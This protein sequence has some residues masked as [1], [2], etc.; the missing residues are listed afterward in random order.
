MI[1]SKDPVDWTVDEVVQFICHEEPGEWSHNLPRPDLQALE[2][3]LRDNFIS[4]PAFL[5]LT[6]AM[7]KD[8]GVSVIAHCQYVL[9]ASESLQQLSLELRSTQ[10]Q[11]PR[12]EAPAASANSTALLD[13]P[14]EAL[15]P[16]KTPRRMESTL[17]TRPRMPSLPEARSLEEQLGSKPA[18]GQED[19]FDNLLRTYP[20]NENEDD[21]LVPLLG[22]SGSEGK[23]DSETY[24]ELEEDEVRGPPE[25]SDDP[26]ASGLLNSPKQLTVN[27]FNATIDAYIA[28]HQTYFTTTR[29]PKE[30]HKAFDLWTRGQQRLERTDSFLKRYA[31]LEKRLRELRTALGVAEHTSRSSLLKACA[32]LD[33]T[34]SE[35]CLNRWQVS[36]LKKVD[37]PPKVTRP[38]RIP[39]VAKVKE[40]SDGEETLSSDSDSI[41][42]SDFIDESEDG[43]EDEDEEDE[44]MADSESEQSDGNSS[45]E[46]MYEIRKDEIPKDEIPKDE[47]PKDEIPKDEIP[48]DGIRKDEG[49]QDEQKLRPRAHLLHG[50]FRDTSSPDEDLGHLYFEDENYSRPAAKKRRLEVETPSADTPSI[51]EPGDRLALTC[52]KDSEAEKA[53]AILTTAHS[54]AWEDIERSGYLPY[55]VAKALSHEPKQ[56]A[57]RLLNFLEDYVDDVFQDFTREGLQA[58]SEEKLA[59]HGWQ[60]DNAHS[61]MLMANLFISWANITRPPD[62][63]MPENRFKTALAL[64]EEDENDEFAAFFNCLK[65]LAKGYMLWA[66]SPSQVQSNE[67]ETAV[68]P[69]EEEAAVQLNEEEAAVQP[70]EEEAAVQP[71]EEEAAVQPNEEEATFQPNEEEATPRHPPTK[72]KRATARNVTLVQREAQ[73][74]QDSQ[75]EAKKA[76]QE[77]QLSHRDVDSEAIGHPVTFQDPVIYLD[78]HIGERVKPHQL[79]GIQ[80]MFREIVRNERPEGCLLAH[81]MGLG[82]TMQA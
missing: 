64:A 5:K 76:M 16:K 46:F 29:L 20:A 28:D 30:E 43:L 7:V 48:T 51:K 50:P 13:E 69:N 73:K 14:S 68:Q 23:Y 17:V 72:R 65:S 80:F 47:I 18:F 66:F 1:S 67:K 36:I 45:V 62:G 81:T 61:I 25:A 31:H 58:M 63:A 39:R 11:Q 26:S 27:E 75:E 15:A 78:P 42:D 79:R 10:Q 53:F 60:P 57:L 3:A 70:N 49:P 44:V 55:L 40:T 54:M 4:G 12:P 74:R 32:C 82:K 37:P 19:F 9:A 2:I 34:L 59:L 8:L 56:A 71:N 35:M 24:E 41:R 21:D 77:L 33:Q 52:V 6:Y 38:P 22:E